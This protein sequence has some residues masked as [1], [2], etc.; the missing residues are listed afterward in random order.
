MGK[1][2]A[3]EGEKEGRSVEQ[4]KGIW[5]PGKQD[6]IERVVGWEGSQGGV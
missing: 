1:V 5:L 3:S 6:R 2:G 4:V